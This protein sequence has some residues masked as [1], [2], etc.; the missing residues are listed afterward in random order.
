[1]RTQTLLNLLEEN[2]HFSQLDFRVVSNV[3]LMSA[4]SQFFKI[5]VICGWF[6]AFSIHSFILFPGQFFFRRFVE[7]FMI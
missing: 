6:K 1:M 7:T 4:G 5:S 3:A 2:F